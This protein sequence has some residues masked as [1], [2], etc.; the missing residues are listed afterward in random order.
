[1][2]AARQDPAV[3]LDIEVKAPAVMHT[4]SLNR[5]SAWVNSPRDKVTNTDF[6]N[7][8]PEPKTQ[9]IDWAERQ[10]TRSFLFRVAPE[11]R[12]IPS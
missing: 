12:A 7:S 8:N 11:L 9:R 6:H 3:K 2:L 10:S 1:M 4:I 5:V